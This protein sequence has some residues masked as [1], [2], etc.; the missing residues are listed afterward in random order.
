MGHAFRGGNQPERC[1]YG[2]KIKELGRIEF[3]LEFYPDGSW[4]AE[5]TNIEGIATG[6]RNRKDI[7]RLLK[8]AVFTYFEI[9]PYA[10]ADRLIRLPEEPITVAQQVYAAR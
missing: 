6:S 9:P 8:D 2:K 1:R 7:S 3:K 4:S 10:C 5:S